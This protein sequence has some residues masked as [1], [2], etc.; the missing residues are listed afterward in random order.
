MRVY[1]FG[2]GA[3][4]S[5]TDMVGVFGAKGAGLIAMSRMGLPVP[6]GFVIETSVCRAWLSGGEDA[7]ETIWAEVDRGLGHIEALRGYFLGNPDRP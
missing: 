5:V 6:P 2:E 1:T 3:L 4:E 7:V